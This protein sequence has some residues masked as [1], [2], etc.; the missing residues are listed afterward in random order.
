MR[1][2]KVCC[3][4]ERWESGGIESFLYNVL[5][6]LDSQR[7][8]IEI[9]AA[10]IKESIFTEPLRQCGVQFIE[11]SGSQQNL[12]ENYRIF[13]TLLQERRYD[14]LHLNI[15]QGLSLYYSY[16]AKQAGVPVRIAHSHNTALRR[17]PTRWLKLLIHNIAK[18][19]LSK[20]A[21]EFWACSTPAAE[22]LFSKAVQKEKRVQFIPNGIDTRRFQFDAKRREAVRAELG[23][24][25]QFVIGNVGRL[26]YQKNQEF[27]LDVFAE[28]VKKRPESR[29]LLIGE[30]E[31]RQFLQEKAE[32]LHITDSVLF[33]GVCKQVEC[34]FWAMDVFVLTSRFEGFGI[35]LVEAQASG[36][37][38]LC[39]AH[40]PQESKVTPLFQSLPLE[41]GVSSWAQVLWEQQRNE[42]RETGAEQVRDAGFQIEDVSGWIETS[43]ARLAIQ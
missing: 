31:Q 27:L 25:N 16:L 20:Y 41:G 23:L 12:T 11:L 17:S 10:S 34:L 26:C 33:Y 13:R 7:F 35:V 2:I 38:V 43:Y 37:P 32:R 24:R 36:L 19:R 1:P 30:G 14:I 21:T 28:V 5:S 29:L 22:F 40:I 42:N 8:E 6:R 4:C 3:F 18:E 9:V 15:F 39:P